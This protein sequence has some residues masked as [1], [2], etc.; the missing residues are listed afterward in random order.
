MSYTL[1]DTV[2]GTFSGDSNGDNAQFFFKVYSQENQIANTS[3]IKVEV[4]EKN[5]DSY[6]SF[7]D[8]AICG[9]N[10]NGNS[11]IT[12]NF[13]EGT[14]GATILLRTRENTV[15]HASDG[16]LSLTISA[17][18]DT[19]GVSL[20]DGS[21]SRLITFPTIPRGSV[22][23]DITNFDVEDGINI[24]YTSYTNYTE[25][26]NIFIGDVIVRENYELYSGE[27]IQFSDDELYEIYS[28]ISDISE[29][30]KFTL[31][32]MNDSVQIGNT[33]EKIATGTI[34][35][36]ILTCINEYP[37]RGVVYIGGDETTI[38]K[39]IAYIGVNNI[40]QIGI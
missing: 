19:T 18:L 7:D 36:S 30:F 8:D 24:Y 16:T 5:L 12:V 13:H 11:N 9:I 39:G 27:K 38:R 4:Y 10:I 17:T 1:I 37:I 29:I 23:N 34:A 3:D 28:L 35:G 26:L 2:Y 21:A 33:S 22:L 20:G 15:S 14:Q 31:K 32:T 25:K 6:T 40:P